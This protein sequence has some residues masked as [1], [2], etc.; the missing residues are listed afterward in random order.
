MNHIGG[1]F[2]CNHCDEPAF[3]EHCQICHR[4]A[5]FKPDEKTKPS[6]ISDA[7][8][9]MQPPAEPK[10]ARIEPE[11]AKSLFAAWRNALK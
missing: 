2:W 8:V 5:E 3:G 11:R 1:H 6:V 4:P 10:P 9:E 7:E